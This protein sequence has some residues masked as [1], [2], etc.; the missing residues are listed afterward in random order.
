MT[1]P[2]NPYEETFEGFLDTDTAWEI[3]E[4][5]RVDTA[6]S[7]SS[8]IPATILDHPDGGFDPETYGF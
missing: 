2:G 4:R 3:F 8:F 7:A 5:I 1:P 6:P